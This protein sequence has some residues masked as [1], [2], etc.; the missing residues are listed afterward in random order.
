[1]NKI[2]ETQISDKKWLTLRLISD[3]G[4]LMYFAGMALYM[5]S[6]ADGLGTVILSATFL[7][8]WLCILAMLIGII[9]LVSQRIRKLNRRLKKSQLVSGFG[10]VVYGS[11][12]GCL[13]SAASVVTDILFGYE[14]GMCLAAQCVMAA[15]AFICFAFGLPIM[16]SFKPEEQ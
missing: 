11:L 7:L 16:R 6:G 2:Y 15:G 13:L 3:V 9:E 14:T 8:G 10:F 1:M 4:W 5:I 12:A